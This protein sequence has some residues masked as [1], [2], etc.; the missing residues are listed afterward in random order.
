[1]KNLHPDSLAIHFGS[2]KRKEGDAVFPGINTST[3]FYA[4]ADGVGF[5][6]V[7]LKDS[8]PHFYARWG[9]PTVDLLEDRLSELEHG[10]GAIAFASG[11]AAIS[12]LFLSRLKAGD[13]L[14]ISDVCYAGAAELA[15]TMLPLYNI[16]VSSIDT[17]DH[18]AVLEAIRPGKTKLIH[19]ETPANPILRL[20]D[21]QALASIAHG[22]GAELSVDSTIATPIA[23]NPL[24]LQADYVVHSLT[25]Y[26]C[27]HGD[28]LGGIIVARDPNRAADIRQFELI[29]HGAVLSPFSAWLILR[30]LE[31]LPLRMRAHEENARKVSEFLSNHPAISGVNW[32]GHPDHPQAALA[33]RQMRN[34]SGLLSFTVKGDG[35]ELAKKMSDRLELV[36]Y[37]VSIGKTKSLICYIPTE[38]ILRTSFSMS[39]QNKA[40]YQA[41]AENG[42]FR[43][44]VG[45]EN[46]DDIIQDLSQVLA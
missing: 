22:A 44:S 24:T 42:V 41:V 4:S 27:G 6:A 13:H 19:I 35:A 23:T 8:A 32:P 10:A 34:F 14:I 37:A 39:E 5:S 45:L 2:S 7:D 36:S 15:N 20:T 18:D 25:K 46:A 28:A 29:H 9:N 40:R 21:I 12:S 31:T 16:E 33:K 17:T 3:S 43:L 26:I 30:G 11:M 1:M 38:E